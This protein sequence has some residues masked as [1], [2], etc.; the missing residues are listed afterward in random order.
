[1]RWT[2]VGVVLTLSLALLLNPTSFA[3]E[4][5]YVIVPGQ[6][7]GRWP[8][9]RPMDIAALGRPSWRWEG[10]GRDIPYFDVQFFPM[11]PDAGLEVRTCRNGGTGLSVLVARRVDQPRTQGEALRYA[12]AE[13]IRIDTDEGEVRRLLGRPRLTQGWKERHGKVDV[14]VV[15]Y[16][17][18]GL[19]IRVNRADRKVFGLGATRSSAWDVCYQTAFGGKGATRRPELTVVGPQGVP[20]PRM[21]RILP[22]SQD[23]PPE[24]AAFSGKWLGTWAGPKGT[25]SHVLAV[26]EITRAP[27]GRSRVVA[28]WAYHSPG[29]ERVW[30]RISGTLSK[31]LHF[32][33]E[34]GSFTYR[35][36]ADD[37][38]ETIWHASPGEEI[39]AVMHRM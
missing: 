18:P 12:T 14:S 13:G 17:Y 3:Q 11:A 21:L 33:F 15:S 28:V 22:P 38:L 32:K 16:S 5:D 7:V 1:M 19:E 36:L 39:Y 34:G 30:E 2:V 24:H 25:G 23:V 27:E 20:L 26:E 31:E 29:A 6:R 4:Y 8:L 9:G 10:K 35:M 37:V